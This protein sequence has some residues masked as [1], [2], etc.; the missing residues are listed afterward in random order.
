M[1]NTRT[2]SPKERTNAA[3][4]YAAL[5]ALNH[6]VTEISW[7]VVG[8]SAMQIHFSMNKKEAEKVSD[9]DIDILNSLQIDHVIHSS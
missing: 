5:N 1:L 6:I 2:N 3:E 9:R 7:T 8:D 4:M